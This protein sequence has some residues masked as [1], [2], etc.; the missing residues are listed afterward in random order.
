M[1]MAH[2]TEDEK[3]KKKMSGDEID[4]IFQGK[5]AKKPKELEESKEGKLSQTPEIKKKTRKRTGKEGNTN[6]KKTKKKGANV[7]EEGSRAKAK[8]RRTAEGLAIY[9]EEELGIGKHDAGGTPLC[10]FDCSCCF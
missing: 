6:N 1:A 9:T 8:R 4:E 2:A 10:P 7:G 3:Q 5:K